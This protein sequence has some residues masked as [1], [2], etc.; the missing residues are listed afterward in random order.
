MKYTILIIFILTNLT[1]CLKIQQF[2]RNTKCSKISINQNNINYF[3]KGYLKK[4]DKIDI[5][6]EG[7]KSFKAKII[8]EYNLQDDNLIDNEM[9]DEIEKYKFQENNFVFDN[10]IEDKIINE[11]DNKNTNQI[12]STTSNIFSFF[13]VSF[14]YL[15]L[16]SYL[17][18]LQLRKKIYDFMN[19]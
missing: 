16:N 12:V 18:G 2:L 5:Y 6:I 4:N 7:K 19:K 14:L 15:S 17:F 3:D 8:R 11:I 13:F 10:E 1:S 9:E